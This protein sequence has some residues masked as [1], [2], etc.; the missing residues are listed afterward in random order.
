ML[1]GTAAAS[2]SEVGTG[3]SGPAETAGSEVETRGSAAGSEVGTGW[4]GPAAVADGVSLAI[5]FGGPILAALTALGP[6]CY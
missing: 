6:S 1:A 4:S 3:W 2:R 5:G